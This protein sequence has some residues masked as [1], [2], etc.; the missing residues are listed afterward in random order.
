MDSLTHSSQHDVDNEEND[1]RESILRV[2]SRESDIPVASAL[3]SYSKHG[4]K[5]LV[6]FL[7]GSAEPRVGTVCL[8]DARMNIIYQNISPYLYPFTVEYSILVGTSYYLLYT[9]TYI[10]Y[11]LFSYFSWCAFYNLAKYRKLS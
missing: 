3:T 10:Y 1:S 7:N 4:A 9:R 11:Q 6:K 5:E 8:D 2:Y